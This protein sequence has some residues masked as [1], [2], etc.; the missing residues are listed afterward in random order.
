M[1]P[2][3]RI[4][5][6]NAGGTDGWEVLYRTRR[7]AAAGEPV[8]DLTIGDHD[9]R[10]PDLV[11]DEMTRSARA[12]HTGYASVPG[13]RPLREAIAA[14]VTARTGVPTGPENVQV[15][16]G[17][18]GALFSAF[19][20]CLD[21]GDAALYLD[22]YYATYPGTIRACGGIGHALAT[23]PE[24]GF[25]P[26]AET[27]RDAPDARA[28][29]INTPNN[30]TGAVYDPAALAAICDHVRTRGM[31]L[32]SDEVYD[33]Q[34]WSGTHVSPRTL[35]DM[36]ERTLVVG[37][38][39]KSHLMTGARIGWLVGPEEVIAMIGALA[40]TMTYGAPGFLQDAALAALTAGAGI[41]REVSERYRRR[42]DA[43]LDIL[44]GANAIRVIPSQGA[45]YL[46]LDIRATGLSGM[47]FADRL[48]EAHRIG[49]MPG[50]SFGVAAAGHIRLALTRPEDEL[51]RAVSTL[52]TFAGELT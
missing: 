35:P 44:D 7:L 46:M 38:L 49:V 13:I 40:T 15:T 14:R 17:G 42:R 37:S 51:R 19:M 23:R 8:I 33:T 18:Q 22:P 45:M 31:W 11:I 24:D 5:G 29:L 10:T 9:R 47:D 26:T 3:R 25:Q 27:F 20:A 48:L 39:S 2:S 6:I 1:Q 30:P 36:A 21:P 43:V 16:G 34:V 52:V 28:L 12:G 4:R 50:E 32:I 41:A